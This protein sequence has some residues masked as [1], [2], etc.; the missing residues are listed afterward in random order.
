MHCST[1]EEINFDLRAQNLKPGT[2]SLLC[3]LPFI[4]FQH[5]HKYHHWKDPMSLEHHYMMSNIIMWCPDDVMLFLVGMIAHAPGRYAE[6]ISLLGVA[7]PK[8]TLS[9]SFC[10]VRN[11]GPCTYGDTLPW[12][13][14][15]AP[16]SNQL[17]YNLLLKTYWKHINNW[18]VK[19]LG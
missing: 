13:L 1:L 16:A 7:M 5:W 4:S 10:R 11:C 12:V 3:I 14:Q 15:C 17:G 2:P 18:N 9:F 8:Q 19:S 6:Q